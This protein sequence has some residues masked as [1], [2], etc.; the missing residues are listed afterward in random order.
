M[1]QIQIATQTQTVTQ[2]QI[3]T[4]IQTVTQTQI[5]IQIQMATQIPDSDS[6][7]DAGK[8]T[9]VK[10]MSATKDHHNKAKS[11]TRNR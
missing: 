4:Q 8:H 6:D 7:S 3:A 11:I 5:A 10:P 1:T 9:P 2:T